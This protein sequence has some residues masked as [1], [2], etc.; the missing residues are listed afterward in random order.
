MRS[1]VSGRGG[2]TP[3]CSSAMAA[4]SDW[5]IQ[6]GRY[7]SPSASR[8]SNTGWFCGCSTRMPTTRTSPICVR[9]PH[10]TPNQV[11]TKSS[12]QRSRTSRTADL[13]SE[14]CKAVSYTHLDVYKRQPVA[15]PW[16][17]RPSPADTRPFLGCTGD[18][19]PTPVGIQR[20]AAPRA[21]DCLQQTTPLR[22]RGRFHRGW[23]SWPHK[24]DVYK[25]QPIHFCTG[26][27]GT[28]R[29]SSAP[30]P[31]CSSGV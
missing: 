20:C 4:A 15:T 7:R 27:P 29:P 30:S 19:S 14:V 3:C 1:C 23:R 21:A 6:I 17:G 12:P 2:S 28:C 31:R 22:R 26:W 16:A 8:S 9:P 13:I 5:P 11:G 10:M 18:P 25:R 24:I